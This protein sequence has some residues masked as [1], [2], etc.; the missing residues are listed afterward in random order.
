[1]SP[2]IEYMKYALR[3][4]WKD[5]GFAAMAVLSLAIGIGA[6]TAIFS[7]VNGVLLRPLDFPDPQRLVAISISTPVFN[8][9]APLPINIAQIVEWR[10]RTQSFESLGGY[11]NTTISLSGDGRPELIPAAQVSANLFDVL[12]VQPRLGRSFMEQ[13]DH[14]GQHRVVILADSIWRRRF[15]SDPSIVGRKLTLGGAPY[16]V[17]GVLPPDFEFPN[18]SNSVGGLRLT[19]RMEMFRPLGY[20][21]DDAVPH[22]GDL[23]YAGIARLK[24]GVTIERARAELAAAEK[25][26]DSA[27][28]GEDWHVAPVMMPLQQKMTGDIRQSLIVLMAAVGAVLLVLCVNLANLS[29]SRAAGRARESAIRTALGASRWQLARQSLAETGVRRTRYR[30]GVCG[31]ATTARRGAIRFAAAAGCLGGWPRALFCPRAFGHHRFA[32]RNPAGD[33]QRF[34]RRA[35]RDSEI[36]RLLQRRRTNRIAFAKHAGSP[37]GRIMRGA[38][39]HRGS[40]PFQFHAADHHSAGV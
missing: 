1:M 23:N 10:K 19:G 3:T 32:I 6:N 15:G 34:Q 35:L 12:G 8:N 5:R 4:L 26:M 39:G 31:I 28:G 36:H 17:V 38:A 18:E 29:M 7:L 2:E 20:Q 9:G 33:A 30:A 11:R 21:P 16:T 37:R 22:G 13:E 40:V 14:Y 27:I 25:A 24:P